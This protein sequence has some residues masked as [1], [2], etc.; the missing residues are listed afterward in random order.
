MPTG[1]G[2]ADIIFAPKIDHNLPVIIVELKYGLTPTEAINQIKE[3][4]YENRY[5]DNFSRILLVGINY[6]KV[7]KKHECLIEEITHV[8]TLHP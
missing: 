4:Q 2:Y 8:R 6:D 5:K 1:K 7:T 3:R